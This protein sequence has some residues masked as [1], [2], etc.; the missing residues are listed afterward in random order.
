MLKVPFNATF[1]L[2][3]GFLCICLTLLCVT[4]V[5]ERRV[6][7]VSQPCARKWLFSLQQMTLSNQ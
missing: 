1:R 3:P 4:V 6:I 2:P 7:H 5:E